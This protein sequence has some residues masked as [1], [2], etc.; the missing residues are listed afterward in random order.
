MPSY[1][2]K[3]EQPKPATAEVIRH[4]FSQRLG[5]AAE[6]A[7]R[8]LQNW[9]T[10]PKPEIGARIETE[11]ENTEKKEEKAALQAQLKF[12]QMDMDLGQA[13]ATDQT[14]DDD[15]RKPKLKARLAKQAAF[16]GKINASH[17]VIENVGGKTLIASWEPSPLNPEQKCVVFQDQASFRLRYSNELVPSL[18]PKDKPKKLGDFWL[19]HSDRRQYRGVVFKPSGEEVI[20]GCINLWRGWGVQPKQGDWSLIRRH[21]EQV[22]ADRNPKSAEYIIRWIAWAMQHPDRQA[23]VALVLIKRFGFPA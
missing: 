8:H 15:L 7:K 9:P 20:N 16:I 10:L 6:R 2:K 1:A 22:I 17:A 4:P 23:E 3:L 5:K 19:D 12:D 21:I 13:E 14:G 11:R 18:K